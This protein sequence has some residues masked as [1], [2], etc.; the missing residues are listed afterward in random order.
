MQKL[1]LATVIGPKE[2]PTYELEESSAA[3]DRPS[4]CVSMS[5]RVRLSVLCVCAYIDFSS[6]FAFGIESLLI[7]LRPSTC[8]SQPLECAESGGKV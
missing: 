7:A 6:S 4:G 1:S 5:A 3:V 2:V 8:S